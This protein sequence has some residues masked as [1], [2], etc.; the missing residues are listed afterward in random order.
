M[1]ATQIPGTGCVIVHTNV[2][3]LTANFVF[4]M[5]FDLIVLILTA[6]RLLQLRGSHQNGLVNVL[7][8]DGLIYFICAYVAISEYLGAFDRVTRRL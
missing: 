1:D 5:A 8:Y 3:V 2:T 4:S 7:F 6:Y